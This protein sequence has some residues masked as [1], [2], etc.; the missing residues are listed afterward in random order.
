[1]KRRQF[2][3]LAAGAALGVG[4]PG[5]VRAQVESP[6]IATASDFTAITPPLPVSMPPGEVE[7]V[8]FFSFACPYC[9]AFETPLE[10]WLP[11]KPP[12]V[13]FRRSPVPFEQNFRNFQPMYFALES[14]DPVG[15][16][17][18]RIFDAVHKE[19]LRLDNIRD[20][21]AF[22]QRNGV[23]ADKFVDAFTS[24]GTAAKVA[25]ANELFHASGANSVPMMMVQGRF[26]TS[27]A[28]ARGYDKVLAVVDRLAEQARAA[29]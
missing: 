11:S 4:R 5:L 27:P 9:F 10:A 13:R 14:L 15:R 26:L 24:P 6:V 1:L 18:R 25:Q 8:E 3:A 17:P 21:A 29:G 19:H 20:I 23:D 7:V 28:I 12:E 16:M 2:S 22:M